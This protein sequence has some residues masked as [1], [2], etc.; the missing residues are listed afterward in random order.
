M[1]S[2][3]RYRTVPSTMNQ[4]IAFSIDPFKTLKYL[5]DPEVDTVTREMQTK[6]YAGKT[7]SLLSGL[8]AAGEYDSWSVQFVHPG[9]PEPSGTRGI[10]PS[11]CTP[12]DPT[13]YHPSA[14][15]PVRPTSP[16]PWPYCYHH[17]FSSVV[18]IRTSV[19]AQD[20]TPPIRLPGRES[21]RLDT[22]RREDSRRRE[23]Q[24]Q[25]NRL[26]QPSHPSAALGAQYASFDTANDC[27]Q[28]LRDAEYED[29]VQSELDE[30]YDEPQEIT[31]VVNATYDLSTIDAP[32]EPADFL[33]EKAFLE[34]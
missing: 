25:A 33:K 23:K 27:S 11:M 26:A 1:A 14:R 21:N 4:Y 16:L 10:A 6:T 22:Y 17:T 30:T 20:A 9:L 32:A 8:I 29:D 3:R 18:S 15:R 12:I 28:R 19:E 7:E 24:V 13:T 5:D 2:I 34:Q 31:A